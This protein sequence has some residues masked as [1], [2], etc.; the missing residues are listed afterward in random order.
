VLADHQTPPGLAPPAIAPYDSG[1]LF[2]SLF[3]VHKARSPF[4]IKRSIASLYNR[5]LFSQFFY[6]SMPTT[7]ATLSLS[8]QKFSLD[9]WTLV[10]SKCAHSHIGY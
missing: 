9:R 1:L 7:P 8:Q 2:C 3:A 6:L 10:L 4:S 5:L